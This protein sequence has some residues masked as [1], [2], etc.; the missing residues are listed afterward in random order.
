MFIKNQKKRLEIL[1]KENEEQHQ[2]LLKSEG[3]VEELEGALNNTMKWKTFWK[4]SFFVA[5][6]VLIYN[7]LM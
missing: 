1:A 2:K 5:L 7:L 3:L 6:I 4:N